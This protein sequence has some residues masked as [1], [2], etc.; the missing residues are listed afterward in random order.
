[1]QCGVVLHL[2]R[3]AATG[4]LQAECSMAK[5]CD[6]TDCQHGSQQGHALVQISDMLWPSI[7]AVWPLV[8]GAQPARLALHMALIN[9]WLCTRH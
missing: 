8:W 3:G 5:H 4:T 1:M 7:T 2:V 6:V 9:H